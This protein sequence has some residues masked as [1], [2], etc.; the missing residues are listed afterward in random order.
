MHCR[1]EAATERSSFFPN[2][3]MASYVYH[4]RDAKDIVEA[5]NAV[6]TEREKSPA[7]QPP[8]DPSDHGDPTWVLNLFSF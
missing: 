4:S 3:N 2:P 1:A 8:K 6:L 7:Y 5:L